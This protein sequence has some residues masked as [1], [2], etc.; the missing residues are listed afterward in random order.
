MRH[1]PILGI[2]LLGSCVCATAAPVD[3]PSVSPAVQ[4]ERDAGRR[5]IL[6][7]ELNAEQA[8][9]TAARGTKPVDPLK[10]HE[11]ELNVA[12][13]QRELGAAPA[14]R[15]KVR[16]APA[17]PVAPVAP[18]ALA[19]APRIEDPAPFWDVYRRVATSTTRKEA[20]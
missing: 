6:T 20:P 9:L 13:L 18:T 3:F 17:A 12:A 5:E 7:A 19:S 15:V 1:L 16:A 8:A 10:V 4:Q 14:L 11:H 2:A